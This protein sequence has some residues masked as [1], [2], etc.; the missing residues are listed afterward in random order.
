[1]IEVK[2]EFS[3]RERLWFGPLFALFVGIIA[4]VL[5]RRFHWQQGAWVISGLAAGLIAVYYAVPTLQTRI[6]RGWMLSVAPIGYVV[7][8]GL[9]A[10]VYYFLL[11]PIALVMRLLNYDPLLRRIDAQAT[12]YWR[13]RKQ[14]IGPQDYFRQY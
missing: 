2:K 14:S 11:T 4:W 12:S 8:H 10:L 5:V 1:M 7:S 9:L 3:E 13:P 6:Y